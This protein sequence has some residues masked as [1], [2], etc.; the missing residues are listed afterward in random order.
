MIPVQRRNGI[1][2]FIIPE[3]KNPDSLHFSKINKGDYFW[4]ISPDMMIFENKPAVIKEVRV[5]GFGWDFSG[6]VAEI[7]LIG[8]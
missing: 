2:D 4:Y 1:M 7:N 5:Y 3:I 6:S 8:Q